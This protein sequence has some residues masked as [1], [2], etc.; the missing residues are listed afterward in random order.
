M[1]YKQHIHYLIIQYHTSYNAHCM[2]L[3]LCFGCLD[4]NEYTF[5]H[6]MHM[7]HMYIWNYLGSVFFFRIGNFEN[8][9]CSQLL[10][11]LKREG[12][13][14]WRPNFPFWFRREKKKSWHMVSRVI[15][16][17]WL[18]FLKQPNWL[19]GEHASWNRLD[20]GQWSKNNCLV[21]AMFQ[22]WTFVQVI[23]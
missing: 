10:G 16:S 13:T 2:A 20:Y 4:H 9:D 15:G 11:T 21:S 17:W 18:F 22:E 3:H 8:Y 14:I 6:D 12:S 7:Y 23:N 19:T 5:V 1:H